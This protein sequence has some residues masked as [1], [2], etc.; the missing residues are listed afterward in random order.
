MPHKRNPNV[1]FTKGARAGNSSKY[2]DMYEAWKAQKGKPTGYG[3]GIEAKEYFFEGFLSV[4][5]SYKKK[6]PNSRLI[7]ARIK[8]NGKTYVGKV[9]RVNGRVK[10]FVTPEVARKI[11]PRANLTQK[12]WSI[13][14]SYGRSWEEVT[15]EEWKHGVDSGRKEAVKRLKEYRENEPGTTFRLVLKREKI[16]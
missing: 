12:Y 14:G 5:D 15:A 13:Q 2:E 8:H 16:A 9:K 11:N 1:W 10:I 6:I 4:P 3:E 7:P